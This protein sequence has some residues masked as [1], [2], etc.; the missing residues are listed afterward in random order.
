VTRA[1]R[2]WIAVIERLQPTWNSARTP[3]RL[4]LTYLQGAD[5]LARMVAEG[6][7][8]FPG[9]ER[10][11]GPVAAGFGQNGA[12]Q[13]WAR[14]GGSIYASPNAQSAYRRLGLAR[15]PDRSRASAW[16][17]AGLIASDEPAG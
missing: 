9:A 11:A 6:T 8:P 13:G 15:R 16:V 1:N 3:S 5:D 4:E 12:A 2:G 10:H 17:T 14:P 7:F